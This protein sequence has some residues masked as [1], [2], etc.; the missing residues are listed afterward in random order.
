MGRAGPLAPDPFAEEAVDNSIQVWRRPEVV[1]WSQ[2]LLDSYRHCVGRELMEQV[3]G[4]EAQAQALFTAPMVVVSH[5]TQDDPILNY[6]SQLALTLWEM[7]WEQL[8]HTPSRLTAEPVNRVEREEML[9]RA[10]TQG[11]ID[12]YRGVRISSSGRRFL[13]EQ[14]VVWNVVDSTGRRQGQAATFSRWT[15]L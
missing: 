13:I 12:N 4:A 14:A 9:E 3:G 15:F 7:T 6:G 5:G 1:E 11:Y 8:V 10:L 2:W